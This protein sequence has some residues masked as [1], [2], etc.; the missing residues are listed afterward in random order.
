MRRGDIVWALLF[1]GAGAFIAAPGTHELFVAAT[2]AQPYLMGFVK[3][4]LLATMGEFLAIRIVRRRYEAPKAL[5]AKVLVWGIIGL[6]VVLM[7]QFFSAGVAGAA[8][9]G[10]LPKAGGFWGSLLAAF[11][12]SAIM[13][14]TFGPVFMACHRISDTWL[15]ARAS[16]ERLR[17]GQVV[18]RIDWPGFV[19]FVV[20]KTVPLFW[21]PAHTITFMLPGE[22]RIL[23]AAFLSIAL[24]AILSF[25][26]TRK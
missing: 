13:N 9:K 18:D 12:T 23:V 1:I 4:A 16:G 17:M 7:F 14:L 24:G 19:K 8:A 11:L 3:F 10:Y 6:L 21:I 22:Y 25:A 20:A 5:A 15:D 2:N 26:K